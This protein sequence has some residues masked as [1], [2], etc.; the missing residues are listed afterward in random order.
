MRFES[1]EQFKSICLVTGGSV[2]TGVGNGGVAGRRRDRIWDHVG[3]VL[4][5]R[6][7]CITDG[8]T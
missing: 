4:G 5:E 3:G 7:V 8:I 1:A 2:R 6:T